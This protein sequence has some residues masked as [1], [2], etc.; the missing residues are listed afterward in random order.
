MTDILDETFAPTNERKFADADFR[1]AMGAFASGITVVTADAQDPIGMTC[2]SFFSL[3]LEPPLIAIAVRKASVT[4]PA[5]RRNG[6]FCVN[7]LAS[8]QEWISSQFAQKGED[9]WRR[10]GWSPS[11][12]GNPVI[13]GSLMW[14]DCYLH[15]EFEAGDHVIAVGRVN[16]F[17]VAEQSPAPLLYYRGRYARVRGTLESV[18]GV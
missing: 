9:R 16:D 4:Y 17:R 13:A 2:Q 6:A 3:S 18:R 1:R 7:V 11:E 15:V 12:L 5:I 8:A 10:V 14:I